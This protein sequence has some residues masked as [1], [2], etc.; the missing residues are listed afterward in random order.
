MR[1]ALVLAAVLLASCRGSGDSPPEVL[2]EINSEYLT[3]LEFMHHFKLRGGSRLS[4]E[5]RHELKRWL[6]AELVDR[7]LLLQEARRRR[8]SSSRDGASAELA[9][10]GAREPAEA[11]WEA[12]DELDE[13]RWIEQLLIVAVPRARPP[14]ESEVRRYVRDHQEEFARADEVNL[15]QIV[16]NSPAKM[17]QVTEM[18]KRGGRFEETAR[19]FSEVP[20]AKDG[21]ALGWC[22]AE[23]V[24]PEVWSAIRKAKNGDTIGPVTSAYGLH[25]LRVLGR[26]NAGQ[27]PAETA[28]S[29]ARRKLAGISRAAQ[30]SK[31]VAG[32][33][34]RATIRIDFSTVDAL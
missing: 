28:L 9:R 20:E 30:V 21:G 34:T 8:V 3:T 27:V 10:L 17:R 32:L 4:G 33:R 5:A 25:L 16:V 26:R 24:P 13:Q 12:G 7:K 18:L 15:R 14:T 11:A 2:G 23:D 29:R 22:S 19:R 31:Y 1:R 6:V